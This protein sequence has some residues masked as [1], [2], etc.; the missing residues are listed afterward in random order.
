MEVRLQS[1]KSPC[2]PHDH[3]FSNWFDLDT[4]QRK[5]AQ[6]L[7]RFSQEE[8]TDPLC[9]LWV[10]R[11]G[12]LLVFRKETVWVKEELPLTFTFKTPLCRHRYAPFTWQAP[13]QRILSAKLCVRYWIPQ[14]ASTLF[15]TI[16]AAPKQFFLA[17]TQLEFQLQQF[18]RHEW[19]KS[20]DNYLQR[21]LEEVCQRDIRRQWEGEG[22]QE[23]ALTL[24]PLE[25]LALSLPR[26]V[27]WPACA[28]QEG[29][30]DIWV[31]VRVFRIRQ[32]WALWRQTYKGRERRSRHIHAFA[33]LLSSN[34]QWPPWEDSTHI[35][36]VIKTEKREPDHPGLGTDEILNSLPQCLRQATDITNKTRMAMAAVF[37]EAG[38]DQEGLKEYLKYVNNRSRQF[39][40]K[41]R[42]SLKQR[43]HVKGLYRATAKYIL[44][45]NPPS[46]HSIQRGS[47]E[48]LSCPFT[49]LTEGL[50]PRKLENAPCVRC[51][52][53]I[54]RGPVQFI[55]GKLESEM[56]SES[57][58]GAPLPEQSP[59]QTAPQAAQ[60]HVQSARP[61]PRCSIK[62]GAH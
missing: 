13:D 38:L 33:R 1:S 57:L 40:E 61:N 35:P 28:A 15:R 20:F 51:A 49:R 50:D 5:A 46:C 59:G 10:C 18:E 4:Q 42:R 62:K 25:S 14:R 41:E 31:R 45:R 43:V 44:E 52:G 58:G 21:C 24:S 29:L 36:L 9:R 32:S 3:F 11:S 55:R 47:Y 27:P 6:R 37:V 26:S 60:A 30:L 2:A 19:A 48:G 23:R 56:K 12:S 16:T 53:R 22:Y 39:T 54:I 7:I 17:M 8:P 34:V